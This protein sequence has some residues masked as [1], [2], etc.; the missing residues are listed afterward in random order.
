M[1][2]TN[3][4]TNHITNPV[5]YA[6]KYPVL[7]YVVT[8][9][10][11]IKQ[12]AAR[13]QIALDE[14]MEQLVYDTGMQV[15]IKGIGYEAVMEL[16]PV[17]RYYW[18]VFVCADNGEIGESEVA[19]FETGK[20]EQPWQAKWIGLKG[21]AVSASPMV[22][23]SFPVHKK[24]VKARAYVSGLGLYE[25]YLNGEKVNDG[26]LQPGF[27]NYN[28]WM[29]YQTY[30]ITPYIEQGENVIAFLMGDGWYK[31]RFGVNGGFENNF[32]DDYKL[33]C[34]LHITYEDGTEE[35]V[36]SDRSF[37]YSEGSIL[38]SNIYDG[39]I[40]DANK[41]PEE[42][43]QPGFLDGGWNAMTELEEERENLKERLTERYSV[44]VIKKEVLK[45]QIIS[46]KEESI[47]LDMGQNMT[48]WLVF[49]DFMKKGETI[50]LKYVEHMEDEEICQKNLLTAK[51]EFKYTSDGKG[52]LVRPHFTYYGFRYVQI[53][54]EGMSKESC[55][56]ILEDV[57]EGWVLYSDLQTTGYIKT[58][59]DKV[60]HLIANAFWSQKDN[61]LDH[62]SDCPQRS[63][64]LG[65]TGDAQMYCGTAGFFMDT[66]PFFRKYM[67]DVNEEQKHRNGMVPFIIPK[68]A[69][70]GF[71]EKKED[72]ASAAWSDAAV[73][74]PW[75]QYVYYGDK[76]V[77]REEY[78]GMKAWVEYMIS[79]DKE[80]GEKYLWQTGFHFGDWLALDNPE[81]GPFGLTDC[82]YVASC[83]YFYST[84]LLAKAAGVLGYETDVR[85]Y[86]ERAEK[87]RKAIQKE[88]FDEKGICKIDTQTG[89][90]LSIQMDIVPKEAQELNGQCLE[91][92]IKANGGHL[93]T[94]FVGTPYICRALSKVGK[95]E[96]AY[97]L[98]FKEDYP[99]WLF[100]VN[101]GA[102]TIWE[103][104]D[105]LDEQGRLTRDSSLNHY[106][107]GSVVE[108]IYRDVC[109]IN[110]M[111]EYPGFEKV[112]LKPRTD[113]RL[114]NAEVRVETAAGVYQVSWKR[115]HENVEMNIEI[116]FDGSAY[117]QLED[118]SELQKLEAGIH[119]F[120][121][122]LDLH[123]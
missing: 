13:I 98:L 48:G 42:W 34:E 10:S 44:P 76:G 25:C 111:E 45:P 14:K 73:I 92:K 61:F 2:I 52:K 116:P 110:P 8:E 91:E 121:Y 103:N 1:K 107:F 114:G 106:T 19:Y 38:F 4:R 36:G 37:K 64:R 78:D 87:I 60:N 51:Q 97:S 31:G 68:I 20:C 9:S 109:G 122:N 55:K 49:S 56:G 101:Q 23:K 12:N 82:Y 118:G 35:Y 18:K 33:I 47:I 27:H 53:E 105:A 86:T 113:E 88:Y 123:F 29:Q 67:K 79:K 77:L 57:F 62:P 43:M 84:S 81:P 32:G 15:A 50:A 117:L 93:D 69:G 17:T 22:R 104:W 102:T 115:T 40:L 99:S 70:R 7:S 72:E 95:D 120:S 80:N 59:N 39:E 28:Y 108:W 85:T 5:G 100:Q 30:D 63:E 41:E 119:E 24:I 46:R 75:N 66:L 21:N 26:Y 11:G 96:L 71:E 54:L 58:G 89:Y 83:Y 112:W 6:M 94:G 74:I 16:K 3:L 65:W 90:V